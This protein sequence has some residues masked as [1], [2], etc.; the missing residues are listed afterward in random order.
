MFQPLVL[1]RNRPIVK[2]EK[3]SFSSIKEIIKF[4]HVIMMLIYCTASF[5]IILSIYPAFLNDRAMT[6]VNIEIL[7]YFW[8]IENNNSH[9]GKQ[10]GE[11]IQVSH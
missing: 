1:S 8:F 5:G 7:F 6:P 2:S 4:P 11:K 9:Y 3:F 10:V